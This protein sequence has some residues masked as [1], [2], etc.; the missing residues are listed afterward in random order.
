MKTGFFGTLG[1]NSIK[2]LEDGRKVFYPQG[3]LGRRGY[4]VSSGDQEREIRRSVR[5]F[6]I[7]VIIACGLL[8]GILVPLFSELNTF[9]FFILVGIGAFFGWL[10]AHLYFQKHTRA[11]ERVETANTPITHWIQMGETLSAGTL[12][13]FT[14]LF[15]LF[16]IGSF[17]LYGEDGDPI[18]LFTGS[19]FGLMLLPYG[20]A[21]WGK[22]R[23]NKD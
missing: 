9:L 5:N 2:T 20:L 22:Y 17:W 19:L 3:P 13:F 7:W 4:L 21:I 11:M 15:L 18:L 16:A 12:I 6:Y 1:N 8:G 14:L 10:A 23:N